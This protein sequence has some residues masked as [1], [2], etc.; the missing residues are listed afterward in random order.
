MIDDISPAFEKLVKEWL[1]NSTL[2]EILADN[3]LDEEALLHILLREGHIAP[4]P[5]LETLI[6]YDGEDSSY[7]D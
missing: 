4:P 5:Y 6:N 2:V 1:G 7:D 3:D